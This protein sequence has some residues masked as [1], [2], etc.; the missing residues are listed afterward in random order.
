MVTHWAHN[1]EISG[2][3]PLAA[4]KIKRL[5]KK[6]MKTVNNIFD[7]AFFAAEADKS[8]GRSTIVKS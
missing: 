5:I 4:T 8:L 1:P 3:I 2:S 6:T 7:F